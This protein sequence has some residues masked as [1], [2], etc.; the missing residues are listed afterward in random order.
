MGKWLGPPHEEI[1]R[2]G[3]KTRPGYPCGHYA[4]KNGRCRYHGGKSTGAKN[5]HREIKH[6]LYTKEVI[7]NNKFLR[8]LL[9]ASN[10]T[11]ADIGW[12]QPCRV[13]RCII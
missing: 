7:A 11:I 1:L 6:G 10:Q 5:P 2:C 3:A 13:N 9:Q 8:E 12:Q 4:M